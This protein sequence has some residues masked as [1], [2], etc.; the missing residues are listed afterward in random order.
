MS[1]AMDAIPQSAIR[2]TVLFVAGAESPV[3]S[4]ARTAD[5]AAA[6]RESLG[7]AVAGM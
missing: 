3:G 5:P 7:N 4:I 2:C 6:H 1:H